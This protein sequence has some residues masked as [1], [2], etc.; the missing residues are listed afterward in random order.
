MTQD[1]QRPTPPRCPDCDRLLGHDHREGCK[2]LSRQPIPCAT[3]CVA[4][5]RMNMEG[6]R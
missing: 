1:T 4:W 3:E 2:I 5:A 6:A